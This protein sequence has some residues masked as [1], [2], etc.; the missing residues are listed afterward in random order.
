MLFVVSVGITSGAVLLVHMHRSAIAG[1][2]EREYNG[3]EKWWNSLALGLVTPGTLVIQLLPI[4][5]FLA[6]AEAV[7]QYHSAIGITTMAVTG[8]F[9]LVQVALWV[10]QNFL[11]T[12]VQKALKRCS[13]PA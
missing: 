3:K 8:L 2:M 5:A 11:R 6:I 13:A 7:R 9:A 12:V 1:A 4:G 10:W